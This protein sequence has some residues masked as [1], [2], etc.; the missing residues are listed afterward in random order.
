MRPEFIDE[1]MHVD[2]K[3]ICILNLLISFGRFRAL[4]QDVNQ[5]QEVDQD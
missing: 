5:I 4:D 2:E 1:M 3:Q